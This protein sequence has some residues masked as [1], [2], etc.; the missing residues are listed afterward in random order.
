MRVLGARQPASLPL[1]LLFFFSF[2]E[3]VLSSVWGR[4]I[5]SPAQV[6]SFAGL[7]LSWTPPD[8]TLDWS[9]VVVWKRSGRTCKQRT[10]IWHVNFFRESFFFSEESLWNS[11]LKFWVWRDFKPEMSCA[12]ISI[13][14]WSAQP[15][16]AVV[17]DSPAVVPRLTLCSSSELLQV[18]LLPSLLTF[19]DLLL[20]LSG[21]NFSIFFAGIKVDLFLPQK[22]EILILN[23]LSICVSLWWIQGIAKII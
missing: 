3:T 7:D 11:K 22:S 8:D 12:L 15:S 2:G 18:T 20:S 5:W 10:Y 1:R 13:H 14:I 9:M 17:C 6:T 21:C 23:Y 16:F 19:Y 4:N